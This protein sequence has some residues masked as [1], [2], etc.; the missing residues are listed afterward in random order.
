MRR[1]NHAAHAYVREFGA[2]MLGYVVV[3]V[4]S[5]SLIQ[6]LPG[7]PWRVPMALAPVVPLSLALWAFVRFY[8]RLDE[9]QRRIQLDALACSFGGTILV[10]ISY[11]FLQ[12]VGLPALSW[13]WV[14]PLMIAL[15]GVGAAL[16][17]RRYR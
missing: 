2:A 1:M 11:G 14:A 3:L 15:W 6:S 4:V 7:S 9:L 8:Q 10:T 5:I 13:V 12:N 16:A 17:H